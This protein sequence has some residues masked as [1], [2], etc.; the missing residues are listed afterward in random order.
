MMIS[1]FYMIYPSAKIVHG[2][3]L[4]T[5][6][7]GIL[8]NNLKKNSKSYMNLRKSKQVRPYLI[9]KSSILCILVH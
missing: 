9:L 6:Y 4:T 5:K 8:K 2:N 3:W 7:M 1:N